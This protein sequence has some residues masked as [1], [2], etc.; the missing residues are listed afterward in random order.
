MDWEIGTYIYTLIYIKLITNRHLHKK[1][2]FKGFI[3]LM[4]AHMVFCF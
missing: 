3:A 2:N 1:K 4:E